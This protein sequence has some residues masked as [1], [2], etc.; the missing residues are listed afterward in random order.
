[1][2]LFFRFP[3]ERLHVPYLLQNDIYSMFERGFKLNSAAG[4]MQDNLIL[5]VMHKEDCFVSHLAFPLIDHRR[6]SVV[7]VLLA[8]RENMTVIQCDISPDKT[9][10][11]IMFYSNWC[12]NFSYDL[13]VFSNETGNTKDYVTLNHEVQPYIAFDPR[14]G[15]STIAI[16]NFE[17]SSQENTSHEL[18]IYSLS[19]KKVLQRSNLPLRIIIGNQFNL[20][21]SKDGRYL[22]LQKLTD[23]RFGISAYCDMYFFEVE[24]LNLVKYF[25]TMLPG[26]FRVCLVNYKPVFSHCGSYMRLLDHR[27]DGQTEAVTVQIYQLPL[28]MDLQ[29]QCRRIILQHMLKV[30]DVKYLPLP[31]KLKNFLSF[32][33]VS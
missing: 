31:P 5:L 25:T 11:T 22:I 10:S 17:N 18:V 33:P 19:Q 7:S 1:M 16:A 21:Y 2:H 23:N 32:T 24:N 14:S 9:I 12:G 15:H 29:C 28:A 20:L 27:V 4:A 30:E 26:L 8:P 6:H 3:G 13:Y